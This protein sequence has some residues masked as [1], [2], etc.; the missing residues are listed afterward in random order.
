MPHRTLLNRI[1]AEFLEMPGLRLTLPQTQRLC[2]ADR[3]SCEAVLHAL[4]DEH[5]LALRHGSYAR[6]TDASVNGEVEHHRHQHVH[7]SSR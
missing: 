7:R 6:P 3:A 5:F 2:G 1:R 4:V